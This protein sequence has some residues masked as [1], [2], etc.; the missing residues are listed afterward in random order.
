VASADRPKPSL[1]PL[2]APLVPMLLALTITAME[3]RLGHH[4]DHAARLMAFALVALVLVRQGLILFELLGPADDAQVP[5]STSITGSSSA[6]ITL[7][8]L[9]VR[10]RP[11]SGRTRSA[12][13]PARVPAAACVDA[14]SNPRE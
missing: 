3:I 8:T 5:D 12:L 10:A 1:A 13:R 11:Q 14:G 2:V 6:A 4:L 7:P 9:T